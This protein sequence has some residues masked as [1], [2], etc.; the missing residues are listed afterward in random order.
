MEA[1]YDDLAVALAKLGKPDDAIAVL[2]AKE[3]QFPGEYTTE[4]NLGTFLAMKGDVAGALD[5]LKKAIAINPNAHFGREK[6]QI[7]LLE[8][9]QRVAKDK[10][11]A[12]RENFLGIKMDWQEHIGAI[13]KR[14][15]RRSKA[16][17][18]TA[19]VIALVG[20]DALRRRAREPARVACARLGARGARRSAARAAC[21]ATRERT[22]APVFAGSGDVRRVRT[23]DRRQEPDRPRREPE[24][25]GPADREGRRRVGEGSGGRRAPACGR[26][27][28]LAKK[29]LK[30]VFGY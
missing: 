11:L 14:A 10:T 22:R 9:M 6:F 23:R 28:K 12:Q 26:G 24:G 15:T 1:R 27:R 17:V 7:Q 13:S 3:Q 8:Y 5:H 20:L 19:P 25:V 18:P 4:A 30:A 2:A 21:V 29:Q 16:G